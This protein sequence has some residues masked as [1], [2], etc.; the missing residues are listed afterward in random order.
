MD[1][2]QLPTGIRKYIKV[3]GECWLWTG[4]LDGRGYAQGWK[5]PGRKRTRAHRIIW[6]MA[7][8]ATALSGTHVAHNCRN[9]NC[10]NP[11]HL[12]LVTPKENEA[13]KRE[14]LS[15]QSTLRQGAGT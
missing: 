8:N 4:A 10:V 3:M 1:L 15:S 12:E 9:K 11:A 14:R 13:E 7:N 2:S 6:E 5:R